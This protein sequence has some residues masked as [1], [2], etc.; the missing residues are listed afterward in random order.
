M[1]NE[2][3]K[4]KRSQDKWHSG[5]NL[6]IWVLAFAAITVL[7]GILTFWALIEDEMP[8]SRW[9]TD[10]VRLA[11][12]GYANG[13]TLPVAMV[14]ALGIICGII[15]VTGCYDRRADE[16]RIYSWFLILR[17]VV[18]TF[19]FAA[20][21]MDLWRCEVWLGTADSVLRY[22]GDMEYLARSGGCTLTRN[23]YSVLWVIDF[24]MNS[25]AYVV[26][27]RYAAHLA[28]Q[29]YLAIERADAAIGIVTED[30]A[31]FAERRTLSERLPNHTYSTF[32]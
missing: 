20:D 30:R 28:R 11:V 32:A 24:L 15:G 18:T 21:Y 10:Y 26:T 6:R 5:D 3:Y 1:R 29:K 4:E 13:T 8:E 19:V 27:W 16:V 14:G 22:R 9:A 31:E 25:T 2:G 7:Y 23:W 17:I 12:G